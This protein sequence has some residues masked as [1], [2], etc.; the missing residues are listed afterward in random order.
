MYYRIIIL[1]NVLSNHNSYECIIE[2]IH[3]SIQRNG[4]TQIGHVDH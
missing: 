1:M 4:K 2:L 3:P